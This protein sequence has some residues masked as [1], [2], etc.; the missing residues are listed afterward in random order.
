MLKTLTPTELDKLKRL[1]RITDSRNIGTLQIATEDE[2]GFFIGKLINSTLIRFNE[3]DEPITCEIDVN[4]DLLIRL[5]E[6]TDLL[7][8]TRA[9]YMDALGRVF[10]KPL[11]DKRA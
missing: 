5:R 2:D 1:L 6:I 10:K 3:Q 9:E 11:I 8:C 4:E 7:S